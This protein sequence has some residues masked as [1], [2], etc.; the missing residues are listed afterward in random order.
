[1]STKLNFKK[2]TSLGFYF[3]K[4]CYATFRFL[5]TFDSHLCHSV[6]TLS[7]SKLPSS[8]GPLQPSAALSNPPTSPESGN[9]GITGLI[10]VVLEHSSTIFSTFEFET[11]LNLKHFWIWHTFE[12]YILLNLIHFRIWYTFEFD[13]FFELIKIFLLWF[14]VDNAENMMFSNHGVTKTRCCQ[15][16]MFWKRHVLKRSYFQNIIFSKHNIFKILPFQNIIFSKH[17]NFKASSF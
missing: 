6:G 17:H 15:N 1:M 11:L 12:F 9:A 7:Y 8:T 5:L 10:H 16:I 2:K 4:M 13:T 3:S 14:G